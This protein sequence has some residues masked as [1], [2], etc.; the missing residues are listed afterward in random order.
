MSSKFNGLTAPQRSA[1]Q[2]LAAGG[3]I[4]T[5]GAGGIDTATPA[6]VRSI[7]AS[8]AV[9]L[10]MEQLSAA[11]PGGRVDPRVV[12][13]GVIQFDAR[14]YTLEK[15]VKLDLSG[16]APSK[17]GLTLRGLGSETTRFVAQPNAAAANFKG[18]DNIWR[19]FQITAGVSGKA[20]RIKVEGIGF[21]SYFTQNSDGTSRLTDAARVIDIRYAEHLILQDVQTYMRTPN[22]LSMDQ[23]GFYIRQCYYARLA[24][25]RAQ[26]FILVSDLSA[27]YNN[28]TAPRLGGVGYCF[29]ENNAIQG[30]GLNATGCNLAFWL[31]NESGAFISGGDVETTNKV[32]LMSH[33]SAGNTIVGLRNE[34]HYLDSQVALEVPAERFAA[35]FTESTEYNTVSFT[36]MA[37]VPTKSHRSVDLSIGKTNRFS[38]PFSVEMQRS[39]LTLTEAATGVTMSAS[40]DL[41]AFSAAARE[42]TWAG[43]Y[44]SNHAYVSP[45]L[46]P[47]AAGG[48]SISQTYKRV[49]GDGMVAPFVF[50]SGGGSIFRG[51]IV[52]QRRSALEMPL[53]ITGTPSWNAANGGELTVQLTRSH[54]CQRGLRGTTT[55]LG[56]IANGTAFYIRAVPTNDTLVI[57]PIANPGAVSGASLTLSGESAVWVDLPDVSD[58]WVN[59][60]CFV[61]LN[62][63]VSAISL[64]GSNNPVLTLSNIGTFGLAPGVVVKCHGF[65]D[66]RLNVTFTIGA[67][68][69]SGNNLT[70][71]TVTAVGL[72]VS[73]AAASNPVETAYGKV[74]LTQVRLLVRS[75]TSSGSACVWRFTDPIIV[76]GLVSTIN[77]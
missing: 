74:G 35:M 68:D 32:V 45:V 20:L 28:G 55:G 71:S 15:A 75:V 56:G 46:D 16:A 19:M 76:P 42:M 6:F 59:F 37:T 44:G 7:G 67:S 47:A 30:Y 66:T 14:S 51:L 40:A 38:T 8:N 13:Q 48:L 58:D 1:V 77:V 23:F 10:A 61:P 70:L 11:M 60:N 34:Q 50:A 64:N 65:K 57:G 27:S 43:T 41:P 26:N 69:I 72:D 24:N 53:L 29:D 73:T 21:V 36:G 62:Q 4:A 3:V 22:S 9:A 49:S 31:R 5:A 25:L 33:G 63:A 39:K 54:L 52:D 2:A 18:A 12:E 17:F